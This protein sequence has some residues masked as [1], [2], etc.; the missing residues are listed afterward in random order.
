MNPGSIIKLTK[1]AEQ[2]K[3]FREKNNEKW[4]WAMF[5][6][7]LLWLARIITLPPPPNGTLSW[8]PMLIAVLA[9]S[10]FLYT[11]F[12]VLLHI[13]YKSL[14]P[15]VEALLSHNHPIENKETT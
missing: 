2:I 7:G 11:L 1:F 8:F 14:E 12:N 3:K 13:L 5:V 10:F 4:A 9:L 6:L 15:I